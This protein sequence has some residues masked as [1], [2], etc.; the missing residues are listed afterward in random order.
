MRTTPNLK[1]TRFAQLDPGDL[2]LYCSDAGFSVAMAVLEPIDGDKLVLSLGPIFPANLP[3]P[4]VQSPGPVRD[5]LSYGKEYVLMLPCEPQG[6]TSTEPPPDKHSIV[7]GAQ[8]VYIRAN[9]ALSGMPFHPCYVGL[10][11]GKII[12]SNSG[13]IRPQFT[14][15]GGALTH[16]LNWKIVTT[17]PDPRSIL[18][19]PF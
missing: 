9:F 14:K 18:S 17:E 1:A 10:P 12:T 19:Y 4:S 13:G 7:I 15:P 2:F 16:A 5:V 11:E 8:G 3:G 6:W